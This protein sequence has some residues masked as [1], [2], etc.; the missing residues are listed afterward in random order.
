MRLFRCHMKKRTM[1][2]LAAV[3]VAIPVSA[4]VVRNQS[5]AQKRTDKIMELQSQ[6]DRNADK[7]LALDAKINA[8]IY[9]ALKLK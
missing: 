9:E 1:V 2:I 6:L 3:V 4:Q 5:A 7:L 8:I